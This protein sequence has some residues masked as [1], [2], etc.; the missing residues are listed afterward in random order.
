MIRNYYHYV[1]LKQ[2]EIVNEN[3]LL[4]DEITKLKSNMH[5]LTQQLHNLELAFLGNKAVYDK[6][7]EEYQQVNAVKR[8]DNNNDDVFLHLSNKTALKKIR[9]EKM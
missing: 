6:L 3:N 9:K 4:K 8:E 5:T 1:L 7:T 2:Q